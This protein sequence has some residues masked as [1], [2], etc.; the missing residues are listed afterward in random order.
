MYLYCGSFDQYFGHCGC[1][2]FS[3]NPLEFVIPT[4]WFVELVLDPDSVALG[5]SVESSFIAVLSLFL[6]FHSGLVVLEGLLKLE[7]ANCFERMISRN[8]LFLISLLTTRF[9]TFVLVAPFTTSAQ[10]MGDIIPLCIAPR[11][12]SL[13]WLSIILSSD[14]LV[15]S[16]LITAILTLYG[17]ERVHQYH[18]P[19]SRESSF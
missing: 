9:F 18:S 14:C 7:E 13:V 10:D 8:T 15:I 11:A 4:G 16:T 3:F 2:T 12:L 5:K 6:L 19:K 17:V 1:L